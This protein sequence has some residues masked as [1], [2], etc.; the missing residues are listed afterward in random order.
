M[1][2]VR[3]ETGNGGAGW[4]GGF[5][6]LAAAAGNLMGQ[7]GGSLPQQPGPGDT[8]LTTLS[9]PDAP[10]T[11]Y[12]KAHPGSKALT[13][14]QGRLMFQNANGSG[15]AI[16]G[17][18]THQDAKSGAWVA[19][20]PVL[21]QTGNGWRV[22]G[23]ANSIL[24]RSNGTASHTITQTYTDYATKHDSV[25]SL[26][27][28]TLTY[29][30]AFGY[31]FTMGGLTWNL[32]FSAS[33]TYDFSTIVAK[34]Q[35]PKTYTLPVSSTEPLSVN[36]SGQLVGDSHVGLTQA[37]MIPKN[38]KRMACS[39]W[40]Y[41]S[42]GA[43]SFACDDSVFTDKQLPYKID[44]STTMPDPRNGG[45]GSGTYEVSASGGWDYD[46]DSNGMVYSDSGQPATVV[47]WG[48]NYVPINAAVLST[49]CSYNL[50][51]GDDPGACATSPYGA[52]PLAYL[53]TIAFG[54][55]GQTDCCDGWGEDATINNVTMTVNWT[56]PYEGSL[57]SPYNGQTGVSASPT[58]TWNPPDASFGRVAQYVLYFGTSN[59]PPQY[60]WPG[61]TSQTVTGLASGTTYYWY[62]TAQLSQGFVQTS[63]WQF[64]TAQ[65]TAAT[66]TFS[67]GGGTYASGQSVTIG[68]TTQGAT[69]RYTT[70]GTAPSETAGDR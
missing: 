47:F 33:G 43:A 59:P 41:S 6:L 4:M 44:P 54:M 70:N 15:T 7:G 58:L 28:P 65:P 14:A 9:Q 35:G 51:S 61:G 37:V 63:T 27:M 1:R 56:A 21:S 40:T 34:R 25:L 10:D 46:P 18:V 53:A 12:L 23:T 19:N 64:T 52:T 57:V 26:T 2:D 67:P 22:D 3:R 8:A 29:D 20:A 66:P 38:G 50:V 39:A 30:Q 49:T 69:I 45:I 13:H 24:V 32:A 42:S 17:S 31:H 5:L 55:E 36:A 68:T 62:V 11:A 48:A 60:A 16:L